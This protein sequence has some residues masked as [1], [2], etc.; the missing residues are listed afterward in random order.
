MTFGAFLLVF[1]TFNVTFPFAL[2][3]ISLLVSYLYVMIH[4]VPIMYDTVM[5]P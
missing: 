2:F 5:L 3:C 4:D 1:S